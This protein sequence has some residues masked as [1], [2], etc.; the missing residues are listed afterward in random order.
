MWTT[1]AFQLAERPTAALEW[2]ERFLT[3]TK[4]KTQ[5]VTG[6]LGYRGRALIWAA[7]HKE[8]SA[9]SQTDWHERCHPHAVPTALRNC[10][11]KL[12]FGHGL[13]STAL[14]NHSEHFCF[15]IFDQSR[16]SNLGPLDLKK[17]S[18]SKPLFWNG[19]RTIIKVSKKSQQCYWSQVHL[20]LT[21]EAAGESGESSG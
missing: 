11:E 3:M 20:F 8:I 16:R 21:D 14:Q 12:V 17:K 15:I 18:T 9:K 2:P 5:Y 19:P 6:K 7:N 10:S 4:K 1:R 13:N